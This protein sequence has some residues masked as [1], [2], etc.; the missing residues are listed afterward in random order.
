MLVA[1]VQIRRIQSTYRDLITGSSTSS[2]ESRSIMLDTIVPALQRELDGPSP[3]MHLHD[4]GRRLAD[5][6]LPPL[7]HRLVRPLVTRDLA[8]ARQCRLGDDAPGPGGLLDDADLAALDPA[9]HLQVRT[10]IL[11]V[12]A[13]SC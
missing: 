12:A 3:S 4:S 13:L 10:L 8:R 2:H 1:S 7:A 11:S 6:P 5:S 9:A